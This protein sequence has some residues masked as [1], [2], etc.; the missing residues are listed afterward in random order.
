MLHFPL[1][2]YSGSIN[3]IHGWCLEREAA[4]FIGSDSKATLPNINITSCDFTTAF[5]VTS[6]ASEGPKIAVWS[7]SGKLTYIAIRTR[8]IEVQS[9]F[10]MY[11][12]EKENFTDSVWNH[13]ALTCENFKIRMFVNGKGRE[14][15]QL[16]YQPFFQPSDR[17]MAS[18]IIG[19]NL[20]LS[21][22]VQPSGGSVM[23]LYI[24]Q[25]SLSM[26][27]IS[28][29]MTGKITLGYASDFT[30]S[31]VGTVFKPSF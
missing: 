25:G 31:M 23:D 12:W 14:L 18:C 15:K 5:W 11:T 28:D 20:D 10:N 24:I 22:T 30:S 7:V 21:V 2:R 9:Q 17:Y 3:R 13:I 4:V 27:L 6:T 29:L 1:C 19:N 8:T 16:W 26:N